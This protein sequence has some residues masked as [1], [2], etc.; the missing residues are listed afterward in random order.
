LTLPVSIGKLKFSHWIKNI[1][2]KPDLSANEVDILAFTLR[3]VQFISEQERVYMGGY[4][5]G[6]IR[7]GSF[8][9]VIMGDIKWKQF[10]RDS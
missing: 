2:E 10:E 6:A 9:Y 8:D 1:S 7:L 5:K 3:N 4:K